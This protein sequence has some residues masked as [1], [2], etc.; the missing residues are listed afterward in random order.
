MRVWSCHARQEYTASSCCNVKIKFSCDTVRSSLRSRGTSTQTAGMQAYILS[1]L[2]PAVPLRRQATHAQHIHVK[3]H[4]E[5]TCQ[6][7][8]REHASTC[9]TCMGTTAAVRLNFVITSKLCTTRARGRF[10]YTLYLTVCTATPQYAPRTAA[11]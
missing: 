3:C 9:A 11:S 1:S 6:Y 2:H 5:R 10:V 4:R 7:Y 8:I